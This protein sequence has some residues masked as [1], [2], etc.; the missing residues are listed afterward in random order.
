MVISTSFFGFFINMAKFQT[1][2]GL[3]EF[4]IEQSIFYKEFVLE[5]IQDIICPIINKIAD[6]EYIAMEENVLK[7]EITWN[8]YCIKTLEDILS[9]GHGGGNWRRLIISKINNLK[10]EKK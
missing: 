10:G 6:E 4:K 2:K 3:L 5:K 1:R 8:E 7:A 9:N